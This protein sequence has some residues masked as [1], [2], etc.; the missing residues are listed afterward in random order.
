[1]GGLVPT[2]TLPPAP[3]EAAFALPAVGAGHLS[4]EW[5]PLGSFGP[6]PHCGPKRRGVG[7]PG[8]RP[9]QRPAR[10]PPGGRAGTPGRQPSWMPIWSQ[11]AP[12]S[13]RIR[14]RTCRGRE[15]GCLGILGEGGSAPLPPRGLRSKAA[16][17][18]GERPG[19]GPPPGHR[20]PR[21]LGPASCPPRP[22][23]HSP[24]APA[25]PAASASDST[26]PGREAAAT[27]QPA[28]A[29]QPP[30]ARACVLQPPSPRPGP[31]SVDTA[32]GHTAIPPSRFPVGGDPGPK[33]LSSLSEIT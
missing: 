10:A 31:G 28:P 9:S 19:P 5:E 25:G 33:R 17:G 14:Q 30:P 16:G 22:R 15:G 23:A 2:Q 27:P 11:A 4:A 32:C 29:G 26:A 21:P 3:G 1:M 12:H 6:Q 18:D 13:P 8:S 24:L 7:S 20:P